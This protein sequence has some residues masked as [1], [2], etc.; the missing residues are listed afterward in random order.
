METDPKL[1]QRLLPGSDKAGPND[2]NWI[3]RASVSLMLSHFRHLSGSQLLGI[4]RL[5]PSV[6]FI[7]Q[8]EF[9]HI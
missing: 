2:Q 9:D 4:G 7:P 8:N 3:V 5:A 6:A 1:N